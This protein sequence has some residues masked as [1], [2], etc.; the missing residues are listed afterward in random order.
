MN[1]FQHLKI[2]L[3]LEKELLRDG[4]P[5]RDPLRFSLWCEGRGGYILD[6][7]RL[8]I[9]RNIYYQFN[10]YCLNHRNWGYILDMGFISVRGRFDGLMHWVY[11]IT[12]AVLQSQTSEKYA[13]NLYTKHQLQWFS[14][15]SYAASISRWK[16]QTWKNAHVL[17]RITCFFFFSR[18]IDLSGREGLLDKT[19][20]TWNLSNKILAQPELG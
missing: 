4:K 7:G 1:S 3:S 2:D 9:T 10:I 5:V 14:K 8:I 16:Y 15:E 19:A 11:R 20:T 18:L 12:L 6:M 13:V 17:S